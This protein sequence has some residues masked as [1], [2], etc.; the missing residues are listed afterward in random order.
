MSTRTLTASSGGP[1]AFSVEG[2]FITAFVT[3]GG[4]SRATA[5]L[6]TDDPPGGPAHDYIERATMKPTRDGVHLK[7]PT[8]PG[9]GNSTTIISRGSWGSSSV[10]MGSGAEMIVVGRGGRTV[11]NGV[12]L[13]PGVY[14]GGDI[15]G[16]IHGVKVIIR[17]PENS[18]LKVHVSESS[19]VVNG[20]KLKAVDY[21]G[22]GGLTLN[23]D[24][25]RIE[26]ESNN[27][28]LECNGA[29]EEVEATAN[30]GSTIISNL[31]G[32]ARATANNGSVSVT[33][34]AP[35]E[36]V[37]RAN[38]GDVTVRDPLGLHRTGQL[39]VK[40]IA[41]NGSVRAPR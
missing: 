22:V 7:V 35:G 33:A 26:F 27:G 3:V 14:V 18:S 19:F 36:V 12:T 24:V 28:S 1:L 23:G 39:K 17:L 41:N 11:V 32:N 34:R 37:A 38:N 31:Y 6:S 30:N 13:G 16:V 10:R 2:E 5:E 15:P 9:G 4:V 8:P 40:A 20:G 25:D 29:V 21:E